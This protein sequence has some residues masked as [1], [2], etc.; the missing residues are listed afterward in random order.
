M[1]ICNKHESEYDGRAGCRLCYAEEQKRRAQY[2]MTLTDAKKLL[3]GISTEQLLKLCPDYLSYKGM[4]GLVRKFRKAD[5]LKIAETWII[6]DSENPMERQL[7][8]QD[9]P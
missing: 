7:R 6:P 1:K 3:A 8:K 4:Y 2:D 5:I 9:K